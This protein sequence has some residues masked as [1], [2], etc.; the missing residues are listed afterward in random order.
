MKRKKVLVTGASG[1]IGRNIFE[2]LSV[3]DELEVYGTYFSSEPEHK[4]RFIQADLRDRNTIFEITRGMDMVI[5]AAAIT[6]GAADIVSRPFIHVTDNAIMNTL[7]CEAV[8][9]QKV[10]HCVFLSCTVLY[11]MNTGYPVTEC[12]VDYSSI[13]DVYFGGAWMKIFGEKLCEF[14]SRMGNTRFTVIRHS[15]IY[16]PHDTYDISRAHMFAATITKVMQ[17][18]EGGEIIV[19]GDGSERRDL[20]YVDDIIRFIETLTRTEHG[21]LE[22]INIGSGTAYAVREIVEKIVAASE[23][24]ITIRYDASKPSLKTSLVL[25]VTKA[26]KDFLWTPRVS[27]EEGIRKTMR[28]YEEEFGGAL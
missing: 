21:P 17:A 16:G 6:S 2:V 10:P 7:I 20:V 23:K 22:I 8:H 5:H 27:L 24:N 26:R 3:R 25:N 9:V 13:H 4:E 18:P 19:W 11:P 12:D 28:W 1:F 15:N 14:Y